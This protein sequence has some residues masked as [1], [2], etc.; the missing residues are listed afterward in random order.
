MSSPLADAS[1]K[2]WYVVHVRTGFENRVVQ[3]LKERVQLAHLEDQFGEMMVPTEEVLEM[4]AGRK[5]KTPRKFYPGYVLVQMA[6]DE[7]SWYLVCKTPR[8]LGFLGGSKPVPLSEREADAILVRLKAGS[9]RLRPKILYEPGEMVRIIAGS[10]KDFSGVVE[11]VDYEKKNRL[12]VS[13][14]VFGRPT[15]LDIEFS[16]VVKA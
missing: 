13:V 16:D 3:T 10:F 12:R 7:A 15:P 5:C 6:M 9:G 14:F 2:P 8:V 11:E 1:Q 4:R